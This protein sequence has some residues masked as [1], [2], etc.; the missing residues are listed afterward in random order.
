M[1][2]STRQSRGALSGLA[3]EVARP[4]TIATAR[5]IRDAGVQI[6]NGLA[7]AGPAWS[8]EFSASWDVVPAGQSANPRKVKG[9]VYQYSYKNFPLKRFER[10]L[11]SG[12]TRFE[13]VN[14]APHAAIA[15]DQEEGLFFP[16][17][18]GPVKEPVEEGWGRPSSE[19]MRWQIGNT[20]TSARN[21]RYEGELDEPNS[22]IT[23]KKDWFP[24]YVQGGGLQRDLGRGVE[25]GFRD[26]G[27]GAVA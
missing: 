27:P 23:A 14:T 17:S 1:A 2:R 13:I 19:H 7:Q 10:A 16:V 25:L 11:E 24:D 8:G 5:A 21:P 6:T 20:P 22:R 9:R 3:R 18:G 4:L 12:V 15:L 26:S